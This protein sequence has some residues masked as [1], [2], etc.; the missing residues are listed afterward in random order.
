M[1]VL[2]ATTENK[3]TSVTTQF[4]TASSSSKVDT[5]NSSYKNCRMW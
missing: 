5:L 4:K 1:S 2:K 3:K